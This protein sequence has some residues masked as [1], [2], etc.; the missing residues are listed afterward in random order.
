M[1]KKQGE[2]GMGWIR[3]FSSVHMAEVRN[4]YLDHV[5]A[6]QASGKNNETISAQ[7]TPPDIDDVIEKIEAHT[8][9]IMEL[10]KSTFDI[11]SFT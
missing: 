2:V 11:W 10:D 8:K 1:T 5:Q 6:N 7:S 4:D 3:E 9:E